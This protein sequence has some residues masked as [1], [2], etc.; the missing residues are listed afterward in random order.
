MSR[1]YDPPEAIAV[2]TNR[3]SVPAYFIWRKRCH[4]VQSIP[5]YWRLDWGWWWPLHKSRDY[6]L[7][8][9]S[10]GLQVEIYHDLLTDTWFLQR[11]Y[12]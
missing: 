10:T 3:F 6:F 8:R 11:K 9:T 7:I 12:D 5:N 2:M 4:P 1:L